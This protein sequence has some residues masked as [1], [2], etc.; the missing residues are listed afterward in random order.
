MFSSPLD[1]SPHSDAYWSAYKEDEL[2]G[3]NHDAYSRPWTGACQAHVGESP[4][5]NDRAI[6]HAIGSVL[7]LPNEPTCIIMF[8]PCKNPEA[9]HLRHLSNPNVRLLTTL[10][11]GN[12][13]EGFQAP[14]HW[15]K[16]PSES[17]AAV[18]PTMHVIAVATKAGATAHLSPSQVNKFAQTTGLRLAP[19]EDLSHTTMIKA[20]QTH[21]VPK[22]IIRVLPSD[23]Y[24][25]PPIKKSPL[26]PPEP[27]H[28]HLPCIYPL[29]GAPVKGSVVAY[30]DGSCKKHTDGSQTIGAAVHFPATTDTNPISVTIN[31]NGKGPTLTINRAELSGIHQ[32]LIHEGSQLAETLHIYTDSLCSLSLIQRIINTPWTLRD[33]KHLFLLNDILNT[34]RSRSEN[35]QRTCFHKVKSHIGIQGNEKADKKA[36]EAAMDPQST[37]VTEESNNNPYEEKVWVKHV[38][39]PH[40]NDTQPAAAVSLQPQ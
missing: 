2:F 36:N 3:A 17:T 13:C 14:G 26:G 15:L 29:N 10:E 31:P 33:S 28:I 5:E 18:H 25:Q 16:P 4:E 23:T 7:A 20:S 27:K 12:E 34:L 19:K 9:S 24:F 8:I 22:S 38:P 40:P 37:N 21:P 30:T 32:A 35:G 11:A 1:R 39:P 6:R